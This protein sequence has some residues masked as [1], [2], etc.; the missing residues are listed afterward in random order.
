MDQPSGKG[1]SETQLCNR[2]DLRVWDRRLYCLLQGQTRR[3]SQ[4]RCPVS[5]GRLGSGNS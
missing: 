3:C 5:L 1:L 4:R 2:D